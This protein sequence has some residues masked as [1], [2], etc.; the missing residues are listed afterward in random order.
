VFTGID[1]IRLFFVGIAALFALA[2]QYNTKPSEII[3]LTSKYVSL[4]LLCLHGFVLT[5]RSWSIF[6]LG[7]YLT[8][9]VMIRNP[10]GRTGQDG[11][12]FSR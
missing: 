3:D 10:E 5:F 12:V 7:E 4:L 1:A 11:V 8:S 9:N 6:L 2:K